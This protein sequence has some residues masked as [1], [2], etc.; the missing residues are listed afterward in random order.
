MK[1]NIL[2][3]SLLAGTL[4][5]GF[6]SWMSIARAIKVPESSTWIVPMI[7]F[8]LYAIFLCLSAILVR[9]EI[10]FELAVTFSALSSLFFA[11]FVGHFIVSLFS[12]AILLRGLQNIRKD[13]D[14]NVKISLWKSLGVG[15]FKLVIALAILISSQYFF[16]LKNTDG[17]KA[18]PKFDV[19]AISSKL[20][21][22]IL[23]TIDPNF[24]NSQ[25][26]DG[27]TVDQFIVESKKNSSEYF[28]VDEQLIDEQI[29]TNL[30][31]SERELLKQ[32]A[33]EQFSDSKSQL[34]QKNNELILREG[35]KQFSDMT[36]REIRGDEKI[37]DVFAGLIDKKINDYFQPKMES[38]SRSSLFIYILVAILFL[39]VWPLGS[40]LGSICFCFVV[41]IFK[42][43]A[44]FGLIKIE[45]IMVEREVIV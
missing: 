35:R 13:L 36:G 21:E 24:K 25:Q 38:D 1:K 39:T 10:E 14:L 28:S 34:A 12:L 45:K 4:A 30:P 32:Q 26:E 20:V 37:A 31:N 6:F 15:K 43:L 22:P 42:M 2:K 5:A 27:I 23:E 19:S 40:I 8:S 41:F 33:L 17:Q 7:C 29:P 3:Y 18:I 44:Y 16:I 11:L 9:Q